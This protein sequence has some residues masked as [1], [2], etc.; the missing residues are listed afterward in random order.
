MAKQD[1]KI[2]RYKRLLGQYKKAIEANVFKGSQPPE[3]WPW[4][5]HDLR[6]TRKA[7]N[8]FITTLLGTKN[9]Y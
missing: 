2:G 7:M 6:V 1:E 8:D 3:Y 5:E 9:G 4:I